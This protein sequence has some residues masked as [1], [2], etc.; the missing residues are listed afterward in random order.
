[1]GQNDSPKFQADGMALII[2]IEIPV[3]H[4]DDCLSKVKKY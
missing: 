2:I 4:I 1:L 3:H